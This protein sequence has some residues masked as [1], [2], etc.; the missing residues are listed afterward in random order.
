MVGGN[1]N[2]LGN[3]SKMDK[4]TIKEVGGRVREHVISLKW[5]YP[6]SKYV[7]KFLKSFF[8]MRVQL[9]VGFIRE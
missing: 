2:G 9:R 8:L 4:I 3:V 1:T 5:N 6:L 7:K